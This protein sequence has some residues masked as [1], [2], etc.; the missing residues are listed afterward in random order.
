VPAAVL[1]LL[2]AASFGGARADEV[3]D[4]VLAVAA[5]DLITQSDV[6][7]AR[8]LGLI[9]PDRAAADPDREILSR[10]ID[11]ALML[12]EVDRYAP[13]E[14]SAE[15]VERELQAVR[16]RFATP[17]ALAS[18]LAKVG[19]D[20]KALRAR[21]RQDL[22]IRA[23]TEDRFAVPQPSDEECAAYY[24]DHPEAFTED[25]RLLP[26]DAVRDAVAARIANERRQALIKDWTAGLRRR[27][28]ITEVG[29]IAR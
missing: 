13:P 1:V 5:G 21:L 15:A 3:I 24:R 16:S 28:T 7:A 17:Q 25:G 19:M 14:P 23:Y 27:A 29:F 2:L 9:V 4:R 26:L 10:L 8:D 22:R 12:S 18:A 20:E 6:A 11:R